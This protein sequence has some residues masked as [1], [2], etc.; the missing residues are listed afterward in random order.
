MCTTP[1][2]LLLSRISHG[3]AH[4]SGGKKRLWFLIHPV[5]LIVAINNQQEMGPERLSQTNKYT[6]EL[7][8]TV[9]E[10]FISS[11]WPRCEKFL[12]RCTGTYDKVETTTRALRYAVH[13]ET[14]LKV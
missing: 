8:Y 6:K 1:L 10:Y 9:H 13:Q 2:A 12:V 4:R 3:L 7:S 5:S 11:Y 14:L